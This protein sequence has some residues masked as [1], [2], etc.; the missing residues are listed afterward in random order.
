MARVVK[1]MRSDIP[2]VEL[3]K[4][5]HTH[6]NVCEQ[7][8][9]SQMLRMGVCYHD[10]NMDDFSWAGRSEESF[11]VAEGS[12]RLTWE[13][14]AGEQGEIIA[15]KGEQLFLPKGLR[16]TLKATG[17]PAIN[18][19]ALAGSSADVGAAVGPDRAAVLRR[20]GEK[21]HGM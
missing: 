4:G 10:P 19:F 11:Y 17:E 15:R 7:S 6:F 13:G 12:I 1:M 3:V 16:Y 20:A 5:M 8:V 21:L 9:G 2:S 14:E 18:V